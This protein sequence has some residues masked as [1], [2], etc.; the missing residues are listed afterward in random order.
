MLITR[1]QFIYLNDWHA[2]LVF[3]VPGSLTS[4]ICFSTEEVLLSPAGFNII[5]RN[6]DQACS[7]ENCGAINIKH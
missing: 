3:T 4:N 1:F 2:R 6:I 7:H 5:K